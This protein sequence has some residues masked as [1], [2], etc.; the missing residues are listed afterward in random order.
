[1]ADDCSNAV[2]RLVQFSDE[3]ENVSL[4]PHH[5]CLS[6]SMEVDHWGETGEQHHPR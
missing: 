2:A 6:L 3:P 1:V 4:H 5:L